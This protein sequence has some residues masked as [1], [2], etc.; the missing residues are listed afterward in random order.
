MIPKL[1]I[2]IDGNDVLVT[3]PRDVMKGS[4]DLKLLNYVEIDGFIQTTIYDPPEHAGR[5]A[6]NGALRALRQAM[7][8]RS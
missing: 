1:K 7:G 5:A 8:V 6:A 2:E 3:G 4:L